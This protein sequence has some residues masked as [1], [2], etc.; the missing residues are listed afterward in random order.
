M[1]QGGTKM[2]QWEMASSFH[3]GVQELTWKAFPYKGENLGL[4]FWA[5]LDQAMLICWL[6][7][8][9]EEPVVRW[10]IED[11]RFGSVRKQ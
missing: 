4:F 6:V 5:L 1:S 9:D 7:A 3:S 2:S 10:A 8:P 11:R